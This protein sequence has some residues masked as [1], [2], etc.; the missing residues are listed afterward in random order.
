VRELR[1]RGVRFEEVDLPS[2]R[3]IDGIAEV[4]GNSSS[5][6]VAARLKVSGCDTQ[7]QVVTTRPAGSG[8]CST[9]RCPTTSRCTSA[10]CTPR[11]VG[12]QKDG[13]LPRLANILPTYGW[14]VASCWVPIGAE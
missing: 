9:S 13:R 2:L 10:W 4:E 6:A 8:R 11:S 3:T 5:D 7:A 14:F 1:Q 12:D